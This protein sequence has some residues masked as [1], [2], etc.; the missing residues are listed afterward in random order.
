MGDKAG[1]GGERVR[2]RSAKK[3]SRGGRR[4]VGVSGDERVGREVR[5]CEGM[6]GTYGGRKRK[7]E[8][9]LVLL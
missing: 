3:G 2:K 9:R 5:R 6:Y 7:G 8:D 4:G 1:C